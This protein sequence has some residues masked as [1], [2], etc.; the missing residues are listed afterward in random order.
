MP[1]FTHN[2]CLA[3]I[4]VP[5]R[6]LPEHR[7]GL[8]AHFD[9]SC[10]HRAAERCW[11]RPQ[12]H[13]GPA[14]V[15]VGQREE[16]RQ[17]AFA[18]VAFPCE[19]LRARRR[20]CRDSSAAVE[21]RGSMP[22]APTVRSMAGVV[23]VPRCDP[24]VGDRSM[25]SKCPWRE[26]EVATLD[27]DVIDGGNKSARDHLTSDTLLL[28]HPELYETDTS[29]TNRVYNQHSS[30]I[31]YLERLLP[32]PSTRWRHSSPLARLRYEWVCR[33]AHSSRGVESLYQ[34][35]LSAAKL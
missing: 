32:L 16:P 35:A 19:R 11:S 10:L 26:E 3:P 13:V 7:P 15:R 2:S 22:H 27:V 12:E 18:K 33:L 34:P 30:I 24:C 1:G 31:R 21:A 23:L 20:P 28:T 29:E 4:P 8:V 17:V 6:R 9:S 25:K 5:L 14:T